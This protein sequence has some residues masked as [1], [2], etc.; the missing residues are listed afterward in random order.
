VNMKRLV[1][2][3]TGK[4]DVPAHGKDPCVV[5][6]GFWVIGIAGGECADGGRECGDQPGEYD[7]A[8]LFRH[9]RE[10]DVRGGRDPG[11]CW[12]DQGV[13]EMV[14]R[15]SR[16]GEGGGELVRELHFSGGGGDLVKKFFRVMRN[17]FCYGQRGISDQ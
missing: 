12:S 1:G 14:A 7:G 8:E 5:D 4:S 3:E 10:P 9:R 13:P 17:P 16:Y 15:R 6:D 2:Y 11:T